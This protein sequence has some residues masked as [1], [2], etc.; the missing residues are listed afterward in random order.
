MRVFTATGYYLSL[1]RSDNN[2]ASCGSNIGSH[3]RPAVQIVVSQETEGSLRR[4]LLAMTALDHHRQTYFS[5]FLFLTF[6]PFFLLLTFATATAQIV[7][8]DAHGFVGKE[9]QLP[10][11]LINGV[12]TGITVAIEGAF[13]LS[14]PTVFFPE[15]FVVA[16]GDT[17]L[18]SRL[19]KLTDS[20]F[21]FAL[22]IRVGRIT[23][24]MAR[25]TIFWLAGE[26]LAGNDSV[27]VLTFSDLRLNGGE[28]G[29]ATGTITTTS[30]GTPRPYVRFATLE[31][32]Y[33]NPV[34]RF[35]PT[36]WAYRIDKD[37]PVQL[38]LYTNLGEEYII[39]D[40]GFVKAGIHL[41]TFTPGYD[42]SVGVYWA[43]LVTNSG[44]AY[45]PMHVLR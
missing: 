2:A 21:T 40:Q 13:Q 3:A 24:R 7:A 35:N 11:R 28:V 26:A 22:T 29:A 36:T 18:T 23:P 6:V 34:L 12:D 5:S 25:D 1:T 31:Q 38:I 43:R 41:I 4:R 9:V 32:N 33:P 17:V 44:E 20:T 45:K 10:L 8:G 14:N 15:R 30:I 16:A 42:V 27:C 39:L 19:T 37:S